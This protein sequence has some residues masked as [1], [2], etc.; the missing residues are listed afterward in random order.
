MKKEYK[1]CER[2]TWTCKHFGK[3]KLWNIKQIH[4]KCGVCSNKPIH[5]QYA[6]Y[7]NKDI[8]LVG[9]CICIALLLNQYQT[10]LKDWN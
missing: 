10:N 9:I 2:Q 6:F 8:F 1:H 7:E 3:I 5:F 4:K